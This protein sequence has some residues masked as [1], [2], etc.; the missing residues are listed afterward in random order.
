M[1]KII[2]ILTI[3]II[4]SIN[5]KANDRDFNKFVDWLID[6]MLTTVDRNA[7]YGFKDEPGHPHRIALNEYLL[8]LKQIADARRKREGAV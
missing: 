2:S 4:F 3:L 1:K 7:P 6:N 5:A 8:K